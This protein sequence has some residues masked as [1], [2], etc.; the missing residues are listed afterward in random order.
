MY[1]AGRHHHQQVNC[2]A[3]ALRP[4]TNDGLSADHHWTGGEV[5]RFFRPKT[6]QQVLIARSL[7]LVQVAMVLLGHCTESCG[8]VAAVAAALAWGSFG[9]PIKG[10]KATSL[11]IDPLVMQSYKVIMCFLTCFLVIPMGEPF[12]FTPWGIVSGI[13]WVPGATAGI[14]GIRNA[15]LAISVGTWSSLIV[16]SSFSWGI[17]VFREEVKSIPGAFCAMLML[18]AGLGGMSRFSHPPKRKEHIIDE[19]D[20]LEMIPLT[21]SDDLEQ[22]TAPVPGAGGGTSKIAKR[23]AAPQSTDVVGTIAPAMDIEKSAA[24][25]DGPRVPT[26]PPSGGISPM[27]IDSMSKD[28]KKSV[29]DDK[30]GKVADTIILFDGGIVMTRR[31]LGLIGA[32]INGTW[33]GTSLIPLHYAKAKGF[34][35]ASYV[36]SFACGSAIVLVVIWIFRYLFHMH[37]LNWSHREAYAALPPFHLREM[38]LPGFLSGTLYSIGNFSSIIATTHLG[39]GVGYSVCQSAMLVSGVWGIFWF[40]EV[41]GIAAISKWFGAASVA[42]VGILWLSYEHKGESVHRR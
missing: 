32:V 8:W 24:L 20:S 1:L 3:A 12:S 14:Y 27:E 26:P 42:L 34:G 13:F 29:P 17:L 22:T 41:K 25:Q 15:G 6:D 5:N 37:R 36:I 4:S 10:E 18:C 23:K 2:L 16:V 38:W 9:V 33:G 7:L 39:Q 31:Q 11:N 19:D 30:A 35:G 21:G 28:S 40:G